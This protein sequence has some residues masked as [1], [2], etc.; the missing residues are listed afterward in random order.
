MKIRFSDEV[1]T[2]A[3]YAREE[4]M[5]TGWRGVGADHLMLGILRHAD[6]EAC[7]TLSAFGLSL[8]DL[9]THIDSRIFEDSPVPYNEMSSVKLTHAGRGIL[10]MSAFEALKVGLNAVQPIHLLLAISRTSG[11]ATADYFLS[12]GVTTQK[13][14]E[15]IAA[16]GNEAEAAISL[17]KFEDIAGALGEQLSHLYGNGESSQNIFS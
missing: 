3:E 11:N 17:P 8:S 7:R 12:K 4:A 15:K 6:N 2:I 16:S 14:A 1:L 9:K 10:N 13:L 5:R